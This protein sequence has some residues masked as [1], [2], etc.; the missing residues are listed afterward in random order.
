MREVLRRVGRLGPPSL[1]EKG[2]SST[3]SIKDI[4]NMLKA[5]CS[6]RA[7]AVRPGRDIRR[8]ELAEGSSLF[9]IVRSFPSRM[10][11]E[12]RYYDLG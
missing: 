10:E 8:H 9:F 1:K 3:A 12:G 2:V 6:A 4:E 7:V 11:F 5:G